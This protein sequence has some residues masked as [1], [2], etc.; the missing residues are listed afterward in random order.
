MRWTKDF[1]VLLTRSLPSGIVSPVFS[2]DGK[3]FAA[4]CADGVHLW[5]AETGEELHTFATRGVPGGLIELSPD[6]RFVAVINGP[7]VSIWDISSRVRVQ[8]FTGTCVAFSPDGRTLAVGNNDYQRIT[9]S[10][11]LRNLQ[12]GEQKEHLP[13]R[14]GKNG[15]VVVFAGRKSALHAPRL[16]LRLS[17]TSGKHAGNK[18]G[19]RSFRD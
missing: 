12:T 9:F 10:V 16:S 15:Q 5:E 18:Q 7:E 4:E 13:R 11:S 19:S 14:R 17:D 2:P 8:K 6:S 1:Q 3:V